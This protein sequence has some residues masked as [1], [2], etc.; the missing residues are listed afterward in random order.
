MDSK[1]HKDAVGVENGLIL[2]NFQRLCESLPDIPIIVRTPIIP[3]FNDSPS[4]IRPIVDLLGAMPGSPK[5]ELLSYHGFGQPKYKQLGK[6]Y[7]LQGLKPPPEER[8]VTL[9]KVIR[10]GE[11]ILNR[12][13]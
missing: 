11:D 9:R 13:V 1:K 8:M 12:R 6:R 10:S 4:D 5:H 2:E 3:G 7:P